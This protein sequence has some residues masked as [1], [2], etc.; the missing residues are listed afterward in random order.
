MGGMVLWRRKR[1]RMKL[2]ERRVKGLVHL[3][4]LLLLPLLSRVDALRSLRQ[5]R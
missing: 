4:L 2:S 5:A 3:V 1:G